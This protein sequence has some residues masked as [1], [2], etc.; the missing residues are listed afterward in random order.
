[1]SDA[2]ASKPLKAGGWSSKEVLGDL[3]GSASNNHLRSW[4][5]RMLDFFV[6]DCLGH[7]EH[8]LRQ[9]GVS[10]ELTVPY[11]LEKSPNFT[12]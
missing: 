8:H 9:M 3:I 1:M 5:F 10:D 12:V 6:D 11:P 4:G 2:D 7:L